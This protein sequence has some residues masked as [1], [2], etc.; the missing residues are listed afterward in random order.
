M[1]GLA[2]GGLQLSPLSSAPFVPFCGYSLQ[3]LII[4]RTNAD[5]LLARSRAHRRR[6]GT[7]PYRPSRD[8]RLT[9]IYNLSR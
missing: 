2:G 3:S 6:C 8:Q 9:L 7:R 4:A 5:S 1:R